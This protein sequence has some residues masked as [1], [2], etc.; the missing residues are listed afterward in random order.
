VKTTVAILPVSI[1]GYK[2]MNEVEKA[3]EN[4]RNCGLL[5]GKSNQVYEIKLNNCYNCIVNISQYP[6]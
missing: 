3:A 2:I 1:F 4:A 6:K 5:P